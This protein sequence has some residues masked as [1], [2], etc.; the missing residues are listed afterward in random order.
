L[1]LRQRGFLHRRFVA[2]YVSLMA[3]SIRSRQIRFDDLVAAED[4]Q[5]TLMRH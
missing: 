4:E 5:P 3:A 1:L 2:A